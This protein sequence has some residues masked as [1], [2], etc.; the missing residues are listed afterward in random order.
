MDF[1]SWWTFEQII[2]QNTSS[3]LVPLMYPILPSLKLFYINNCLYI[4]VDTFSL[5]Q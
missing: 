4:S 2:I 3:V 5:E 1:Q